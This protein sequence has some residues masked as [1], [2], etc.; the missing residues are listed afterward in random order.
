[1]RRGYMM[2]F[3]NAHKGLS[4]AEMIRQEM[5]ICE[6]VEPLGFDIIWS[7]EHHFDHYSILPDNLQA[8]TYLAG[9]TKRILLGS[10]GV[11]LPWNN[12]LRVAE[13]ICMLDALCDG[14]F[15]FGMGRGLARR[16]YD[17]FG[18]DM[19]EARERF[20][21]AAKM[22]LNA[23]ETGVIEGDGPFYKQKRTEIRPRPT[24]T[25]ADRTYGVAMSPES[26]P[27]VAELGAA[28]MFFNLF[29]LERHLPGV[30]AY[31][32]HFATTHQR[33]APAVH[34]IDVT[35]CDRSA[36]RAEEMSRQYIAGYYLSVLEHYELFTDYH[37]TTKGYEAHGTAV[38]I[39]KAAGE[40]AS[41]DFVDVQAW[42]TPQQIL[43]K[44]DRRRRVL[45]DFE[46]NV[47]ASYAGMPFADVA[48]SVEMLGKH[49][50]PELKSWGT[51]AGP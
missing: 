14:R 34:V 38:E 46:W 50:L 13:K 12:P 10:A 49:V 25:F 32:D 4:D 5:K 28:M 26:A 17:V 40:R 18:I 31:R 42:G 3:Q 2:Q 16:E 11:I 20:N 43:D 44:L 24:R 15:V 48:S 21:E 8:L 33:P 1:M 7:A 51:G 41:Q 19:S 30:E 27:I 23:L 45:G 22:I 39:L 9:R 47:M 35:F 37:K 6:M 29:D 36:A